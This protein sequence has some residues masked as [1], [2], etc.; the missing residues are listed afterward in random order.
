MPDHNQTIF[1]P[2]YMYAVRYSL[3]VHVVPRGLL[4]IDRLE[5]L[6]EVP[7][8]YEAFA[9]DYDAFARH[10][11]ES[12]GYSPFGD[13]ANGSIRLHFGTAPGDDRLAERVDKVFLRR[14]LV[15]VNPA[16]L[17][18]SALAR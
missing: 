8:D 3:F 6:V 17:L 15:G 13:F 10:L 16:Q 18:T 11:A 7:F 12:N 4:A 14:H 9:R 2:Y 1:A 5:P